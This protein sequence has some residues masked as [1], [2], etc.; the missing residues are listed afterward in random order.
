MALWPLSAGLWLSGADAWNFP[1]PGWVCA[2]VAFRIFDMWKPWPVSWA[3][4]RKDAL[5][6]M[7]D[8]LLAGLMAATVT[9]VFLIMSGS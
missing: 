6:V 7:L 8:D 5:G 9:A 3:D 4:R 2:F 1:W